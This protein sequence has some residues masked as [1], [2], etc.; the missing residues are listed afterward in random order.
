MIVKSRKAIPD[1]VNGYF[2]DDVK[3]SVITP[4]ER[5]NLI[6]NP[7]FETNTTGYT[8][9]DGATLTRTTESQRRGVYSLKV[10]PGLSSV[11]GLYYTSSSLTSGS[12]Y[13]FSLDVNIRGG[14]KYQIRVSDN[15]RNLVTK[16]VTGKGYWERV[17]VVFTA[18]TTGA[19]RLYF[20]KD[21]NNNTDVFFT[22]GW[23]LELCEAGNYWPTTYIDGDQL[24]F[25]ANQI[26]PP[27]LWTGAPHASTS[28]RSGLT[29][30]GGRVLSLRDDL[31]FEVNSII[32]LGMDAITNVATPNALIGGA[33]YQR[34][35][36][37]SRR[38]TIVGSLFG[39][40]PDELHRNRRLLLDTLKPDAV[41][42]QQPLVLQYQLKDHETIN[43]IC[44]YASGLEGTFDNFNQEKLAIQFSAFNPFFLQDEGEIASSLSFIKSIS[45]AFTLQRSSNG[46]WAAVTGV[47]TNSQVRAITPGNDGYVYYGGD[48]SLVGSPSI[49]ANRIARYKTDGTTATAWERLG[50]IIGA[51]GGTVRAIAIGHDGR[52]YATGSFTSMDGVA[53]TAGIAVWNPATNTWA[54]LGTG[55][56]GGTGWALTVGLDGSIYVGGDFTSVG[57]VA[58][59]ARIARWTPT[60]NNWN[61]CDAGITDLL[62]DALA[63]MLDGTI[64]AAGTFNSVVGVADTSRIARYDPDTDT[65]SSISSSI[66]NSCEVLAVA[67]DGTLYAGGDF[68]TIGGVTA[69]N[70][71]SFNGVSWTPLGSGASPGG[72]AVTAIVIDLYGNVIVSGN[73]SGMG[74]LTSLIDSVAVWNGSS[75]V[76]LA[77]NVAAG[78]LADATPGAVAKD[79]TLY[80][81]QN[82]TSPPA[83]TAEAITTITNNGESES[84][85]VIVF[86]G[87][88]R[89]VQLSNWTTGDF[90]YFDL[91][92]AD[93]ERAILTLRPGNISFISN[94]R[95]NLM[96]T[97]LPGSSLAT[98]KLQPGA[99]RI[100]CFIVDAGANCSASMRWK[101]QHWG[102]EGSLRRG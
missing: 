30:A 102:I 100:G 70:I 72:K 75:W 63:T 1:L 96:S 12:T 10:K 66:T 87:G 24:G 45:A 54:A 68:G 76:Y 88:G 79:G 15:A 5:M 89:L 3:L 86:T 33:F 52:V 99:N 51:V 84:Y 19:H 78:S 17:S 42:L 13:A 65:W 2:L 22:D 20:E 29:R 23:Q 47:G 9:V 46:N 77:I 32:G 7:S 98:F 56:S 69:Q 25:V 71:A 62:C 85:P 43:I 57:G 11:S 50:S 6:S 26:P 31:A 90:I 49:T 80:M 39:S 64:V 60:T 93:N 97:I 35:T 73:F 92:L 83:V 4:I 27:Y 28:T 94:N 37:Q 101:N 81:K 58:N 34:T 55:I 53:N 59:T 41:G 38:F 40:T 67:P 44:N 48:F 82:N 18:V 8:I 61:A 16:K 74:N 36:P 21:S 91:T 14:R 95:G